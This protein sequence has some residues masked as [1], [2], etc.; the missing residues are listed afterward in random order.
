ME[1]SRGKKSVIDAVYTEES[2]V[3]CSE[4]GRN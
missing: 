3:Q 4:G 2:A 1:L